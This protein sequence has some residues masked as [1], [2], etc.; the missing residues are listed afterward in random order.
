ML[1][2]IE[3]L[4]SDFKQSIIQ[5]EAEVRSK[6]IVPLL[7]ILNYPSYL[8]SEE[9]PVYGFEGGKRLP[10]K[11]AD[12]LLFASKE[13][14][15]HRGYTQND[16]DWVQKNSLLVVEAKKPGEMPEISGQPQYYTIWTKAIAYLAIDGERIRGYYY[17][18]T[19]V[20]YKIIDCTLDDLAQHPAIRA[21][22]YDEICHIK[23]MGSELAKKLALSAI[24]EH[25]MDFDDSR[26]ATEDDI[27][28]IPERTF[29]YMR[30]ALGRNSEGLSDFQ[31]LA[32]FLNMTNFYLQQDLRYDVPA[33]MLDIPRKHHKTHLFVNNDIFPT[34]SGEIVEFYRND[35]ERYIYESNNIMI[36]AAF[37]KGK[38]KLLEIGF[39]AY[40]NC[41][42][43][44]I[45]SFNRINKILTA[46]AI[47]LSYIE[48]SP[49]MLTLMPQKSRRLWT[50]KN[51]VLNSYAA[52]RQDLDQ[53]KLIEEFY[54]IEFNLEYLPADRVDELH[55]A[56]FHIHSGI[57]FEQ[58]C[59]INLPGG[60]FNDDIE[61]CE[62]QVFEEVIIQQ[63]KPYTLFGVTFVPC[64][65]WILPCR[66]KMAGTTI[67]D[68][69]TVPGCI[70]YEIV[71]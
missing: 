48:D 16:I 67:S 11:N 29:R 57:A 12:F 21:F 63:M 25:E 19:D 23:E 53:L 27:K 64:K 52:W 5:S 18:V 46:K 34:D 62:H 69:V 9:F 49:K 36:G 6:F 31:L 35:S 39:R 70:R 44:R 43:E 20:D 2:K 54:E 13:F 10:T 68:I 30:H 66:L 8:R 45:S 17:S 60:L 32:K 42:T 37:E 38:I 47:R 24:N 58:N 50:A 1:H 55:M 65:S 51:D 28:G 3:K 22:S 71:K 33:Y 61:L 59:E 15:A 26:P 4:V 56:L 7:D 40:E 14:A 41:V